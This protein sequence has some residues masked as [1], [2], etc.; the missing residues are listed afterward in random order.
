[1]IEHSGDIHLLGPLSRPVARVIAAGDIELSG[2]LEVGEVLSRG[3]EIRVSGRLT[4][5]SVLAQAGDVLVSGDSRIT[6]LGAPAGAAR[7]SGKVEL[8]R[9]QAL[10]V[11]LRAQEELLFEVFTA[12]GLTVQIPE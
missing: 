8:G 10:V 1:M 9:V 4:S 7:V 3:G 11:S 12:F 2:D 6:E 5:R